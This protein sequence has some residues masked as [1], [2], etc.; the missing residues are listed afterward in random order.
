MKT[1]VKTFALALTL[2]LVST[3]ATFAETNP[4][5]KKAAQAATFKTGIY[6]TVSG[7]LNIALDK[8][9]G[10]PVDIR[11]KSSD[12]RV[13]YNYRLG[14][15]EEIYRTQLNLTDLEDGVYQLEVTNGVETTTQAVK[16]STHKPSIVNRVV[17]IQ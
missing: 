10:G 8:E 16:L 9:K 3:V 1:L 13:L 17:A 6:T 7:K 12:G 5:T 4:G 2:G 15:K 14:K 11:L